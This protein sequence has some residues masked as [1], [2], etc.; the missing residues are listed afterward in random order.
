MQAFLNIEDGFDIIIFVKSL[1]HKVLANGQFL[2]SSKKSFPIFY[3]LK[4]Q[5]TYF[6]R[7]LHLKV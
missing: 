7:T 1:H 2:V 4:C 5:S 3:K 6:L